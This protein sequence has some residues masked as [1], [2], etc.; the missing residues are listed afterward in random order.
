MISLEIKMVLRLKK[1]SGLVHKLKA[2]KCIVLH[3]ICIMFW[4]KGGGG[5]KEEQVNVYQSFYL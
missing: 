2:R 1:T 5:G 3:K 4:E